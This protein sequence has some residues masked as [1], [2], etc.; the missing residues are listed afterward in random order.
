MI[1]LIAKAILCEF[2]I[3]KDIYF[4]GKASFYKLWFYLKTTDEM[5]FDR[6][7]IIIVVDFD[8]IYH[9]KSFMFFPTKFFHY[10][11]TNLYLP[12]DF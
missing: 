12:F 9:P 4:Y 8:F 5:R 6:D 3:E 2:K 10:I 1:L 7:T 11:Q